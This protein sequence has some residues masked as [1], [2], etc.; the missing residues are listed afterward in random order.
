M[1]AGLGVMF[2]AGLDE[3]REPPF[4][5]GFFEVHFNFRDLLVVRQLVLLRAKRSLGWRYTQLSAQTETTHLLLVDTLGAC[6]WSAP[7]L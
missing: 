2:L 4:F 7:L 5:S 6:H 1:L 3:V